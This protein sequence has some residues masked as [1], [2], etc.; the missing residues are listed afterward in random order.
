MAASSSVNARIKAASG[1]GLIG[2]EQGATAFRAALLPGVL[3]VMSLAVLS[4]GKFLGLMPTVPPLLEG[5]ASR[6]AATGW[7]S[8]S[9][10]VTLE[11]IMKSLEST[12][13]T[14]VDADA[15]VKEAGL[16]SLGAVRAR[17]AAAQQASGQT[18]PSTLIFDYPTARQLA[19][20]FESSTHPLLPAAAKLRKWPPP[21]ETR[22]QGVRRARVF[23]CSVY[24]YGSVCPTRRQTCVLL[25]WWVRTC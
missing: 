17:Q 1:M 23:L 12:T 15:P 10:V 13:G 14:G 25:W 16:D 5:H 22:W 21:G 24:V 2:L 19:A 3:A 8:E 6:K 11:M 9:R 4:W 7:A 20:Y 18:L